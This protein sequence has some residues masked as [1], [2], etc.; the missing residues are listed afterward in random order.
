MTENNAFCWSEKLGSETSFQQKKYRV[1]NT[2]LTQEEYAK[3]KIP[4]HKLEFDKN[5]SF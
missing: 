2:Q 4:N 5:E 3:I 1:F